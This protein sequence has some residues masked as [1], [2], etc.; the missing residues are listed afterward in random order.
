MAV[1]C[2]IIQRS[3]WIPCFHLFPP[4]YII[5]SSL[6]CFLMISAW[7]FRSFLQATDSSR[8]HFLGRRDGECLSPLPF[9]LLSSQ[10]I[11]TEGSK[12]KQ[13][14]QIPL[15]IC[16]PLGRMNGYGSSKRAHLFLPGCRAVSSDITVSLYGHAPSRPHP[17]EGTVRERKKFFLSCPAWK[18]I[19]PTTQLSN[20]C[21]IS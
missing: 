13:L 9:I 11:M 4:L 12:T 14:L 2:F 7:R 5:F 10:W 16:R 8:K 15:S 21:K 18:S 19:S 1:S 3:Q 17:F 20:I 6:S